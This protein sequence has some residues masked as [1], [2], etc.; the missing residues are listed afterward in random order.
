MMA[1]TQKDEN[2][3]YE[4]KKVKEDA[5]SPEGKRGLV[6]VRSGSSMAALVVEQA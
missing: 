5:K 4:P 1:L 6:R 3:D 2:E